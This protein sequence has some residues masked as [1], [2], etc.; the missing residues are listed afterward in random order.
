MSAPIAHET[1]TSVTS[2]HPEATARRPVLLGEQL[3]GKSYF[4][5][6]WIGAKER[7]VTQVFD[8][9]TRELLGTVP[10]HGRPEVELCIEAAEQAFRRWRCQ[11]ASER[12]A[13][14]RSWAQAMRA[15]RD[16]LADLITME[17]GKPRAESCAEVEYAASFL[18]WFADEAVR[19][20]GVTLQSHL[21]NA[22]LSVWREPVGIAAAI[23]PW[24][25]PAAMITRKAG[26]ALAAGCTMIVHPAPQ[27][28]YS[29]LAL[30]RLAEHAGIPPGVF[31]VVTG[32]AV[33]FADAVM[34]SMAVRQISF[35][36]STAV[37]RH[38]LQR[39]AATV[40]RVAME[41]GGHAPFLVFEDAD[42]DRAV[43][44]CI[45]A[46]FA[47]TGQDCL[48]ANR[49]LVHETR[50]AEFCERF[51][52]AVRRLK[53]GNGFDSGVDLGPLIDSAA[54][55]KCE[56][57]IADALACG[58]KLLLGGRRHELGGTFFQP[59]VLADLSAQARIFHEETFGPV[60]AIARFADEREAIAIANDSIY[61]LA[62]YVYTRDVSRAARVS[63]ALEYGMVMVNTAKMTGP[64]VPF[65]GM[66]QSGLGREG[67]RWGLDE[68]TELKCVCIDIGE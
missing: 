64:P 45:A 11:L 39:A 8:P 35:T 23:T 2:T 54:V 60:A 18:D 33:E 63:A 3:P 29:A 65:G 62:A 27:T 5:G 43:A 30:A 28:P 34:D 31:S 68:Y 16:E 26:A 55:E 61:G 44:G 56:A 7:G 58:A 41:L 12:R 9:A 24:N 67:S 53:T 38:L 40:K 17:Q 48:A 47:T 15:H 1:D 59:T 51:V 42:L 19:A 25:F 4:C 10:D 32:S 57:H 49:I 22:Q 13:L 37:G 36:G 66:K 52:A 14:L 21:R 46:K 20:D 50:Y 6:R